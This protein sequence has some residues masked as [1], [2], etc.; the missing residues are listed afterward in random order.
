MLNDKNLKCPIC[1]IDVM[2]EIDENQYLH[3][4]NCPVCG[5][6]EYYQGVSDFSTFD[7]NKLRAFLAY[8]GYSNKDEEVRY[9]S[10]RPKKDCA[11]LKKMYKK[12]ELLGGYPVHLDEID[13]NNWYPDTFAEKIDNILLWLGTKTSYWGE[14]L[15]LYKEEAVGHLFIERYADV[16]SKSLEEDILKEQFRYIVDYLVAQ[17]FVSAPNSWTG[18]TYDRPIVLSP[19]GYSR[20]DELVKQRSHKKTAFVAMQFGEET[21]ELRE[22]IREGIQRA[23]YIAVF[24]DEVE[25][26][27]FITPELLKYIRE[28]KFVVV[29]LTYKN[30]GAYFEEGYALGLGKTVIQ[31]CRKDT[32]LHFDIAQKNTIIWATETEIPSRLKSRINATIEC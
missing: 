12:G 25:H 6:F 31:L 29:D 2:T 21:G 18:G 19:N 28:A 3:I 5:R 10:F 26:N 13:V 11:K 8:N 27:D 9:F 14:T 23:G 4:Y 15:K 16:S 32:K 7:V 22:A 17:E 24:I 20:I 1:G 30:N